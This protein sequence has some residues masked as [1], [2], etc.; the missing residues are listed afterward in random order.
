MIDFK[1]DD[2][3]QQWLSEQPDDCCLKGTRLARSLYT[4]MEGTRFESKQSILSIV[5]QEKDK[6][7][8][9][10][11]KVVRTIH[12]D[13]F[14]FKTR[15]DHNV[16]IA[17]IQDLE[18]DQQLHGPDDPFANDN[19]TLMI[20]C[21]HGR[22]E[23]AIQVLLQWLTTNFLTRY[24]GSPVHVMKDNVIVNTRGSEKAR[25][26]HNLALRFEALTDRVTRAKDRTTRDADGAIRD[27]VNLE[28]ATLKKLINQ[29]SAVFR[30]SSLS[31]VYEVSE[32]H[33]PTVLFMFHEKFFYETMNER[34]SMTSAPAWILLMFVRHAKEITKR[35]VEIL[36]ELTRTGRSIKNDT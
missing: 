9:V 30:E 36:E 19:S 28:K 25:A 7:K 31:F 11:W 5:T 20:R 8:A 18:S 3:Y 35:G 14:R 2:T 26:E 29:L 10:D 4:L 21:D 17:P 12:E 15:R 33:T 1:Y 32:P 13:G 22:E 6:T 27:K 16:D 24:N 34:E 23:E